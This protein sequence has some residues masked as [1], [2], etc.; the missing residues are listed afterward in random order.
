MKESLVPNQ[1]MPDMQRLISEHGNHLLRMCYLYLHDLQLAEDAVQETYIKMYKNWG[2]FRKDCS[3][4]TWITAIAINV[5]KSYLRSS[6]YRQWRLPANQ[7]Y[8]PSYEDKIRDD[9][10]LKEIAKLK[11]KYREVILLFYYEQLKVKEI[12]HIL[13]ITESAVT[14][15]LARARKQLKISLKGWYF[16]E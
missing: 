2:S 12:A 7:D 8:E 15:R 13:H 11:P 4:K 6:W 9:T 3:E 14:V 16:N 5:C 10:V 1:E